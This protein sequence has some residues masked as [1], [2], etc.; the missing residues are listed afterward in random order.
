[1]LYISLLPIEILFFEYIIGVVARIALVA[2]F[3]IKQARQGGR[4][5]SNVHHNLRS[6][7]ALIVGSG[8]VLPLR[9]ILNIN[10][11]SFRKF[12]KS[13]GAF[14]GFGKGEINPLRK[15]S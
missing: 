13:R 2:Y 14:A 10:G 1:M 9:K 5:G 15:G 6:I 4:S 7:V 12:Y 8:I 11:F 3:V